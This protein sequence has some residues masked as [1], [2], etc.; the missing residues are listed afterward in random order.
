EA[1]ARD[2]EPRARRAAAQAEAV[3][4]RRAL[5][6]RA[7]VRLRPRDERVAGSWR[8]DRQALAG[9]VWSP[10]GR[11]ADSEAARATR[12]QGDLL[13]AGGDGAA[14]S[15]GAEA[16]RRGRA[17]SGDPRLDPRA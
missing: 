15:R 10:P 11:A 8:V 3:A 1:L 6:G 13:R 12:H 2:R 14:L 4:R 17:R 9:P 5:R 16:R 7:L